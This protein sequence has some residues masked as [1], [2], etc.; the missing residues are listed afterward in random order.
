VAFAEFPRSALDEP[1]GALFER[2]A[3]R[4]P[5]RVAAQG[6]RHS[7]TYADMDRLANAVAHAVLASRGPGLEPIA[8]L[9]PHD[10]LVLGAIL[11]VLKAG[12]AYVALDPHHAPERL[13]AILRDAGARAVVADGTEVG[14]ARAVAPADCEVLDAGVLHLADPRPSPGVDVSARALASISYTSGSTGQPRGVMWDHRGLL[15]RV[16]LIVNRAR[17]T[18]ADRVALLQSVAVGASFRRIFG[19][20]LTGGAVFPFDVRG[21]RVDALLPWLAREGIT[22]CGFAASVLRHFAASPAGPES[23]PRLRRVWLQSETVL[24]RDVQA[25][26]ALF[27]SAEVVT[28]LSTS[29]AGS[30]VEVVL[31]EATPLGP[32]AAPVGY[33]LPDK[34][35]LLLDEDPRPVA[36]GEVGEIAVRS[37]FLALGY[38]RRPDHEAQVF[39]PDPDGGARRIC[40][41]RDLGQLLPD[42]CLVHLGRKDARVKLRGSFVDTRE[43]EMTLL[44]HPAISGAVVSVREDRPGDQ[45]LV[46]HVVPRMPGPPPVSDLRELLQRTLG[47]ANV[48]SA[49]VFMPAFPRTPNG[50]VDRRALP[51]PGRARPPLAGRRVAPRTPVEETVAGI[52]AETLDL[53]PDE[54]GI[55]DGFLDLG[56]TSL[57]AGRIAARVCERLRVEIPMRALLEAPCVADQ[58][59][60]VVAHLLE[61]MAPEARNRLLTSLEGEDGRRG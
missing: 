13:A 50:K 35:I 19:A 29:E 20:L 55:N 60:V 59:A 43:V 45:R 34:E 6:P 17:M 58:A 42:G 11:G 18:P 9:F 31:D 23:F 39:L 40:L 41:T 1:I 12:K 16:W 53:D 14:R 32:S 21:E 49:F 54:V 2:Q 33:P 24:S 22:L 47:G 25:C 57:I 61:S 27:P 52:W 36:P 37:E 44:Q 8:L 4:F 30:L 3:A 28:G 7:L 51:A 26:R 5:H 15:H 56:G 46:A 38:W 10:A 48:P